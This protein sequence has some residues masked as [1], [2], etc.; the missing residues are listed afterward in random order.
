M[1]YVER[2]ASTLGIRELQVHALPAAAGFYLRL[3][4]TPFTFDTDNHE[5]IQLH[6][7]I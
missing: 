2:L 7:M 4:Y 1:D 6:K 5:S 3:G